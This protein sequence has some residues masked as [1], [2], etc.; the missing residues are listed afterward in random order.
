MG[1][2][3]NKVRTMRTNARTKP[4]VT[5]GRYVLEHFP[6]TNVLSYKEWWD[7]LKPGSKTGNFIIHMSNQPGVLVNIITHNSSRESMK[8]IELINTNDPASQPVTIWTD[9]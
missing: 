9:R 1:G 7:H 6:G 2:I 3:V 5:N 8:R 4:A